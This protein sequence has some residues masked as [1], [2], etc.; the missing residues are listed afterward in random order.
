MCKSPVFEVVEYCFYSALARA[1]YLTDAPQEAWEPHFRAV[2]I[3]CGHLTEWAARC[4][5]NFSDRASLVAA[6][7]ARLE[8]REL[9][10]Q[11]LYEKAIAC[12]REYDFVQNEA[13]AN[14][15]AGRFYASRQLNVIADAYLVNARSC[16]LRWGADGKVRQIDRR[17]P[18][19]ENQRSSRSPALAGNV[20]RFQDL[21]VAAVVEM[22]QRC[23]ERSYWTG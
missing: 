5:A 15:L 23:P 13:L 18:H 16:Y 17:Y 21:D 14:E 11:Q 9:D 20:T 12:A 10:A 22:Y 6:E 19:L 1:A 7:F 8:G 3:S 4:P 2:K